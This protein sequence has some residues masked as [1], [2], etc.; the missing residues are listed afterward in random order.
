MSDP[1]RSAEI[2]NLA[3]KIAG[4]GVEPDV[5]ELARDI[6]RAQIDLGRIR[7][8][9]HDFLSRK[10]GNPNFTPKRFLKMGHEALKEMR[11]IMRVSKPGLFLPARVE[12][13]H[14]FI[15]YWRPQGAEKLV[16]I[17]SDL[18]HQLIAM[19]RYERRALSRRKFAIRAFDLAIRQAAKAALPGT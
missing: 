3:V 14:D 7:Q 9:R 16:Y 17:F 19:D 8:A 2:E 12:E 1:N 11:R 6:A 4:K 13:L 10:I 18:S 15:M 5:V